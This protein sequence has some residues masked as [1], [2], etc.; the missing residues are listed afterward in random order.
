MPIALL[1]VSDMVAP[2]IGPHPPPPNAPGIGRAR[3]MQVAD[4][5]EQHRVMIEAVENHTPQ[6]R[7]AAL[8]SAAARLPRRSLPLFWPL[9]TP[10]S[11]KPIP[12]PSSLIEP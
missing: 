1:P 9:H 4:P 5:G 11:L 2:L 6:A 3:R 12:K 7:S 10:L 8:P